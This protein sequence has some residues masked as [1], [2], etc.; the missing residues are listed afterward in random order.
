M[1]SAGTIWAELRRRKV[2]RVAATYGVAAWLVIQVAETVF[3]PLLLPTW[4]L[5]L[6]VVLAILGFPVAIALA[7]AFEITLAGV[8]KDP[9]MVKPPANEPAAAAL[10]TAEATTSPPHASVAVLPFVDMSEAH[11]QGYFCDGVAE[12]ILNSLTQV[13]GLSVAARTSSF[14]FKGQSGDIADIARRLNVAAVLEGSV[15][16]SGE[17]LRVTAQLVAAK[18]GFHLWSERFDVDA[19]DVFAVQERIAASIA[20]AL[21]VSLDPE[22]RALM[23][24]GQTRSL[25]AYDYYLRGL[26]YFHA[27]SWRTMEYARQMF[28]KAIELDAGFGRAW[29]GLAY[30]AGYIYLYRQA[31]E[32]Y[33]QEALDASA[34]AL[35]CCDTSE[36]HTARGVALW[37]SKDYEPAVAE[38]RRALDINPGQYEALWLYGR[39]AHERGDYAKAAEL[40][41][42][43][44]TLNGDD[45]QAAMLLPQVFMA[46]QQPD[47]AREWEE[48]G[49]ARALRHLDRHPD[50][51]RAIYMSAVAYAELGQPEQ[52]RKAAERALRLEPDDGIVAYNLACMYATLDEPDTAV[53]LLERAMLGGRINSAWLEH[54]A[55][56]APLKGHPRFEVLLARLKSQA[57]AR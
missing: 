6:V 22:D 48:R 15:R 25:E 9:G 16:K 18:D 1:D 45:Y 50:D 14:Q 30:A 44:A 10:P 24:R 2:V 55:T 8:R 21:R 3:E 47:H 52:A 34:R 43:A 20:S 35:E 33:R 7:W 36:G 42:R 23:L 40:W 38:F 53:E 32:S 17:R 26:S 56:L 49:L 29:A 51:V 5:T 37:L 57:M 13:R 39:L 31:D 12:E 11:D 41:Q 19:V 54:D 46:L 28:L 27:F 4:A